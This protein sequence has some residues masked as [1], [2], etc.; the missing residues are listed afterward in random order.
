[1]NVG[2]SIGTV[3]G[4]GF[5]GT[6]EDA[7][8]GV[9]VGAARSAIVDINDG[10]GRKGCSRSGPSSVDGGCGNVAETTSNNS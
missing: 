7:A 8:V 1:M 10:M 6:T 9:S 5:A 4:R 3:K 2:V